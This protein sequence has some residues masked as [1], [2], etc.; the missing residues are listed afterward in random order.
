M[1]LL[2]IGKD[3]NGILSS[4]GTAVV[5]TFDTLYLLES[6]VRKFYYNIFPLT[7]Y[8]QVQFIK[9]HCTVNANK[10]IKYKLKKKRLSARWEKDLLVKKHIMTIKE[11]KNRQ[12]KRDII[13]R[14]NLEDG[15]A[16][17]S[18]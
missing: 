12:L 13:I 9:V 5:L 18:I 3:E 11:R 8:F 1:V 4:S 2:S 7:L 17:R 16:K 10:S 14:V 6:Y 15:I